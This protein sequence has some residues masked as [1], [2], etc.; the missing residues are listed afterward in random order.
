MPPS[1]FSTPNCSHVSRLGLRLGG[2]RQPCTWRTA[3]HLALPKLPQP[4]SSDLEF[5]GML[6][7]APTGDPERHAML[8][9]RRSLTAV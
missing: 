8:S 7:N 4:P 5:P 6:I 1:D 3:F 2:R 9:G